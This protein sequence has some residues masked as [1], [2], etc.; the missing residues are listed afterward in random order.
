MSM[1]LE[2]GTLSEE[3]WYEHTLKDVVQLCNHHGLDAVIKDIMQRWAESKPMREGLSQ[4]RSSEKLTEFS[5]A[6]LVARE[7]T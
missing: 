2:D 3:F 4:E 5:L 7:Q 6:P 1:P